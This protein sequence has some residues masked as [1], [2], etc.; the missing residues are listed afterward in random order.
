MTDLN[1]TDDEL[2]TQAME[3]VIALHRAP[4]DAGVRQDVHL[5]AQRWRGDDS[6][7]ARIFAEAERVWRLSGELAPTTA[8]GWPMRGFKTG[9]RRR[10]VATILALAAA[11]LLA[12]VAPGGLHALRGDVVTAAAEIRILDLADGSRAT[13]APETILRVAYTPERRDVILD[14]GSAFFEVAP[15]AARPFTVRAGDLTARAVGTAY[16]VERVA[17]RRTV[18]VAEGIVAV[19]HDGAREGGERLGAG[20][21]LRWTEKGTE[22]GERGHRAAE[23]IAPWR[24]H[25]I[26]LNRRSIREAAAEIG[27]WYGGS[28]VVWD[29]GIGDKL[30]SGVFDVSDPQAAL[31]ALVEPHGG[32]TRAVGSWLL[33]VTAGS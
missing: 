7:R 30:V 6:R 27:R 16:E 22:P 4:V 33:M 17:A 10:A 5:A 19:R 2:F 12:F 8:A 32:R 23:N 28:I 25:L 26:V 20:D 15:D 13:L 18:A 9:S 24:D 3:L 11:A 31:R 14:S 21:W 1:H 29:D